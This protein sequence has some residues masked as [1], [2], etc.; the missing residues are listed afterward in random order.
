MPVRDF[1]ALSPRYR[2]AVAE[3]ESSPTIAVLSTVRDD[4]ADWLSVGQA[5]EHVL[6]VATVHTV[7]A[8]LLSQALEWP[9][10]RWALRDT[11]AGPNHVQMLVRL[12]YGPVGPET[13]RRELREVLELDRP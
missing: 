1:S 12:G 5:L 10:L 13:P 11:Q 4:P 7:R 2:H 8:S 6:L 9:D 3:F